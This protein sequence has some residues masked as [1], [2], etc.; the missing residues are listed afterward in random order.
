[1]GFR[2][3][4]RV[5]LG[6]VRLECS[7]RAVKAEGVG[8]HGAH[9]AGGHQAR[10]VPRPGQAELLP[11]GTVSSADGDEGRRVRQV[12]YDVAGVARPVLAEADQPDSEHWAVGA[13]RGARTSI[14]GN[15]E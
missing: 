13:V 15:R 4:V 1:M 11:F 2:E 6:Q 8:D 5:H 10:D 7:D 9:T 3:Q 14:E 12:L